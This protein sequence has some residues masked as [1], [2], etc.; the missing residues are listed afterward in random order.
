MALVG[1]VLFV[2]G[3]ASLILAV[4]NGAATPPVTSRIASPPANLVVEG[5]DECDQALC[6]SPNPNPVPAVVGLPIETAAELLHDADYGCSFVDSREDGSPAGTILEQKPAAGQ[7][8]FQSQL[9]HL[10]VS[11]PFGL[12][13]LPR[14]C[15]DRTELDWDDEGLGR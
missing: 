8:G 10:L 15:A 6:A 13:D 5:G 4:T 11:A 2:G 9:V 1:I 12:D 14:R 3:S 7:P